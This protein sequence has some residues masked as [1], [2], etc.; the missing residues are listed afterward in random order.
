[1]EIVYYESQYVAEGR[2]SVQ[3]T[4]AR[5]STILYLRA[6]S[7]NHQQLLIKVSEKVYLFCTLLIAISAEMSEGLC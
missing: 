2:M 5:S 4:G 1:M 3:Q 6:K 7:F